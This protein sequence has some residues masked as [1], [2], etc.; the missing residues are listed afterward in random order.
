M[1]LAVLFA[2]LGLLTLGFIPMMLASPR[3]DWP[4]W[5]IIVTLCSPILMAAAFF[6]AALRIYQRKKRDNAN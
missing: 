4:S 1:R 3:P 6:L 5:M 2:I